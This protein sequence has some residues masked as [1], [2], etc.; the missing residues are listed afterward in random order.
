MSLFEWR[1]GDLLV[2]DNVL[3]AHGRMPFSGARRVLLA[4]T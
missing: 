4:M 3:A 2:V 1:A